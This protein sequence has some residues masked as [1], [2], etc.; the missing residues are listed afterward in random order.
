MNKT[1]LI[2]E[3]DKDLREG[4][5]EIIQSNGYVVVEA[6]DG[7]QALKKITTIEPDLVILDLGLP[8]LSGEAVCKEAK[9]NW[10]HIPI[11]ILTAKGTTQDMVKGLNLGADDYIAKPFETDELLARMSARLRTEGNNSQLQVADLIVDTDTFTVSR[12]NNE[13]SMTPQEF[14]LLEYL[15]INKGKVLQRDMILNRVWQYAPDVESRVVDVYIGYLR[16]KI[17]AGRED[18]KLIKTVRGFG[19]KIE[20]PS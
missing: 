8:T 14:K 19:Y 10:P 2:V 3:D 5:S 15:I 13:I 1:I 9:K 6:N 17:D 11:I 16:K 7:P 4:L 20:D 18:N 12:G